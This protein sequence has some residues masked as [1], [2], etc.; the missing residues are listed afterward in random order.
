V[1]VNEDQNYPLWTEAGFHVFMM[2]TR[3]RRTHW[4]Q[5]YM[6]DVLTIQYTHTTRRAILKN[7]V[8]RRRRTRGNTDLSFIKLGIGRSPHRTLLLFLPVTAHRTRGRGKDMLAGY[9]VPLDGRLFP[10]TSC[11]HPP[12]VLFTFLLA[13]RVKPPFNSITSTTR[14]LLYCFLKRFPT[15]T[16]A[17]RDAW[18]G[19]AYAFSSSFSNR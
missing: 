15:L 17:V 2:H 9:C 13:L 3:H 7:W 18:R 8:F 19:R 4:N 5:V 16:L 10:S 1:A 11:W 14:R 6:L 12:S